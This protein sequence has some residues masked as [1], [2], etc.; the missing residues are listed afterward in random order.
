MNGRVC[1]GSGWTDGQM[2]GWLDG[3]VG[4]AL[5][6]SPGGHEE[7]EDAR[8]SC[9]SLISAYTWL[10]LMAIPAF[11]SFWASILSIIFCC[12][13]CSLACFFA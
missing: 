12:F 3:Q 1:S 7:K 11:S 4:W 6:C 9:L 13:S 10:L 8:L 2:D 5:V